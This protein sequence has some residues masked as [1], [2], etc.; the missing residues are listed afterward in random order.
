[1]SDAGF[2]HPGVGLSADDLRNAQEMVRTGQEPWASYFDAMTQVRPW[3]ALADNS[4]YRRGNHGVVHLLRCSRQPR[5]RIGKRSIRGDCVTSRLFDV[6]FCD[7]TRCKEFLR[8]LQLTTRD[9]GAVARGRDSRSCG[10]IDILKTTGFDSAEC[11]A[12]FHRLAL[13]GKN[14]KHAAAD[15]C[16]HNG[17]TLWS[18]SSRHC[19]SR[20]KNTVRDYCNVLGSDGGRVSKSGIGCFGCS[21]S[22]R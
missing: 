13:I 21:A 14:L 3:A 22:A 17:L 9:V 16:T 7:C 2:V 10:E 18:E 5:T 11:L 6:A 4:I 19:G 8:A 15:L 20:L 12:R 1:V